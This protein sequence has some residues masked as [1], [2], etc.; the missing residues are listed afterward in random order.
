MWL[1]ALTIP[2]TPAS[3]QFYAQLESWILSNY[4][5]SYAGVRF[6]WS[7]GWGYTSSGAWSNTSVLGSTVPAMYTTGQAANDGWSAALA[8]LDSY[9]PNRIFSNSF[10]DTL[11]P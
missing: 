5:G 2:G 8:T 11:M 1:D 3:D 7:K 10:L 9:D 6:E 4:T